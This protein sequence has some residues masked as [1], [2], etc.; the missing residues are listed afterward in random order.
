M[1]QTNGDKYFSRSYIDMKRSTYLVAAVL[2]VIV[3]VVASMKYRQAFTN[4]NAVVTQVYFLSA[5]E[6]RNFLKED[7]DDYVRKMTKVDLYARKAKNAKDYIDRIQQHAL[8]FTET[9]KEMIQIMAEDID[10]AF[11]HLAHTP[12]KLAKMHG[13]HYEDGMPH[14]RKDIIF[15]TDHVLQT[16]NLKNTLL[17]E[18]VHVFQRLNPILMERYMAQEQY[19]KFKHR[20]EEP[21]LRANPDLDDWIY[22]DPRSRK[23]MMALYSSETPSSISDVTL[24]NIAFEHPYEAMAYQVAQ[25]KFDDNKSI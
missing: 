4:Q 18:K 19:R 8:D 7:S 15:V 2:L 11:P 22:I 3:C 25:H 24:T 5:N 14:T 1:L 16:P 9:E 17:H 12:W 10:A 21:L 13:S 20:T 6:T 23:P